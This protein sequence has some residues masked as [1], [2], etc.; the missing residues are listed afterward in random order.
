MQIQR[1]IVTLI[2]NQVGSTCQI[3]VARHTDLSVTEE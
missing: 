3:L 1:T 2:E